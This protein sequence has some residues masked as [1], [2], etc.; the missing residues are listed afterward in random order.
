MHRNPRPAPLRTLA[1]RSMLGVVLAAT[2]LVAAPGASADTARILLVG[3][4]WVAQAWA[5]RAFDTALENAGLGAFTEVG[6]ATTIGGTTASQWATAPYLQLITDALA[7]NPEID[8][9]HVSIGGNDFLGAPPGTDLL[10]LAQQILADQQTVVD[11][12]LGIRPFAHVTLNSYDYTPAGFNVEQQALTTI[13]INQATLTPD[14]FVLNQLGVLHHVFGIAGLHAPGT[15]PLPGN[16]PDYT[17]VAGGDPTQPGQASEFRDSIHPT[18][19]GY[20]ALAG[21][22]ID[23]YYA[24]WLLAPP[25]PLLGP[26]PITLLASVLAGAGL[27]GLRRSARA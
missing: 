15:L 13:M 4:S 16:F 22:A 1:A 6:G 8:I 25:L 10:T 18:D 21:H 12:I 5:A 9:V 26:A 20:V 23:T 27:A 24:A 19:A 14:V 11:H 3:D 17:P 7:A 2:L